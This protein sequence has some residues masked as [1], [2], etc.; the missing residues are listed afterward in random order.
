MTAPNLKGHLERERM[1]AAAE[2]QLQAEQGPF[3]TPWSTLD[4]QYIQS[5]QTEFQIFRQIPSTV[6]SQQ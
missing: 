5:D 3:R 4:R 1:A 6:Q 2:S